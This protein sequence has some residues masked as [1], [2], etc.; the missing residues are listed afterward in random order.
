MKDNGSII[1]NM[2]KE[3]NFI[4]AGSLILDNGKTVKSMVR[5]EL[6]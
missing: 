3:F 1:K 4:Q 6:S 2:G 5:V